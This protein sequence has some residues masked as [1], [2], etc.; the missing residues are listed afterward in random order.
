MNSMLL[1]PRDGLAPMVEGDVCVQ[2]RAPVVPFTASTVE[3]LAAYTVPAASMASEAYTLPGVSKLHRSAP[4]EAVN[5]YT[6]WSFDGTY[7]TPTV[8]T[9]GAA[10][11]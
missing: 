2:T 7:N 5:A 4:V 9:R 11:M 10:E 6:Y 3:L 1:L 8:D